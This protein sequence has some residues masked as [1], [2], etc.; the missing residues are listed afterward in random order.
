MT[1]ELERS[2]SIPGIGRIAKNVLL[3]GVSLIVGASPKSIGE[4]V[5]VSDNTDKYLFKIPNDSISFISY[6][7]GLCF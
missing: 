1:T 6:N 5:F 2:L 7:V 3:S 4:I